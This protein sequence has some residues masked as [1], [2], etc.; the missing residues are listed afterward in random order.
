MENLREQIQALEITPS[1]INMNDTVKQLSDGLYRAAKTCE[2]VHEIVSPRTVEPVPVALNNANERLYAYSSGLCSWEEWDVARKEAVGE[3]SKKHYSMLVEQWSEALESSDPKALWNRISW[4]GNMSGCKTEESPEIS[5]LA[6]QFKSKDSG[7]DDNLL[8]IDF[9]D[10]VVPALDEEISIEEISD[11]SKLLKKG[12]STADGWVP[13]MLNEIK[14]SLFPLLFIIFNIILKHGMVPFTWLFCI[15]TALFKKGLRSIAKNFRP[16]S[17]VLML[18]KH[19]DFILLNRFKKWFKPNDMQTAYQNGK[20]CG[21]HIFFVRCIIQYFN[22]FKMKLFITA[23]DF[24]GAFDRVKRSTLLRKLVRFGAS[25]T[26]VC[27]LANLYSISNNVIFN[28]N[29]NDSVVYILYSGIKQGMPQSPFLFLFYID[30]IF[31]FLEDKCKNS[32]LF[33]RLHILIHVDDANLLATTKN[34]II[35]KIGH[36]LEFCG[37]N[38]ILLQ[39][40]KCWFTVINGTAEDRLPLQVG[41]NDPIKYAEHLEILGS[42]ISGSLRLDL[43]LHF[44]KRFKNVIKFFNFIKENRI[45]PVSVKLK[46]LKSCVMST[47]LYNCEAFGPKIPDG[48]E[49]VYHKMLKAA[50]GVRTNCPILLLYV[51]SG[52]LPLKCLIQSRQ[53]NFFRKFQKSLEP[54]GTRHSIFQHLMSNSTTYL[55]HYKH[56][57]SS[58]STS[59]DLKNEFK[60]MIEEKVRGFGT[61]KDQH[62]KYWIYVQLNPELKPTPFFSRIDRVGKSITNFRLG[63]HAIKIETGRWNRTPRR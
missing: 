1:T 58:Y 28:S 27:C 46:V 17:L 5:D 33:E 15:V 52:F 22:R 2:S 3:I 42:H 47:L 34:L 31:T 40:S 6:T 50:L 25:A 14:E 53:L 32:Q 44:K 29:N 11:A 9:G 24:D 63:S 51:E 49:E 62:Y 10:N 37:I 7:A 57:D 19:F 45:A 56:I 36:L 43:E 35:E 20:C 18:L 16:V 21:D 54:N 55:D 30:D 26:F 41:N 48:L 4:K 8:D 38:S 61:N 59:D 60:N 12:K 23:V 39:A 13:E